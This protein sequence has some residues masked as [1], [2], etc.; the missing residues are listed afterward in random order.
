MRRRQA[1]FF[2]VRGASKGKYAILCSAIQGICG[3]IESRDL[4]GGKNRWRR[5][6]PKRWTLSRRRGT[7][8]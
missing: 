8:I 2:R 6:F 4:Y 7:A 3:R 1:A 5:R